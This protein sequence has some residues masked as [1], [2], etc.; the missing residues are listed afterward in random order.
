MRRPAA[1]AAHRSRS[2]AVELSDD[3]RFAGRVRRLAIISAVALGWLFVLWK[4]SVGG[5]PWAGAALAVGWA[6]MPAVLAASVRRPSVRYALVVPATLVT[7]AVLA[8][9]VAALPAGVAGLGWLAI[10]AGIALGGLLGAWFWMRLAPVP[11]VLDDPFSSGRSALI[12]VHV[13]LVVV[14]FGLATAGAL[15]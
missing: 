2:L 6:A 9:C 4:A 10:A 8:I 7:G 3:E 5:L 1:L 15:A 13:G 11:A 14:G 12:S